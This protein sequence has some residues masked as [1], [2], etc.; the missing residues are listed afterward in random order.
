MMSK[1]RI[2]LVLLVSILFSGCMIPY[3]VKV[4]SMTGRVVDDKTGDPISGVNLMII[5][6]PETTTTSGP[7]G[8]FQTP[9]T[10]FWK[11]FSMPLSDPMYSYNLEVA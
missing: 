4:P 1:S 10:E 3:T 5:D 9:G 6:Y 11:I 2:F 8:R 7:D